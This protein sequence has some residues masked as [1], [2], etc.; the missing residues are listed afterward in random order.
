MEGLQ[1]G[2]GDKDNNSLLATLNVNLLSGGDLEL[3]E[4][5]LELGHVVL[6]VEDGLG[7]G[8]LNLSRLGG[9]RVG[10]SEDLGGVRG[11]LGR[12]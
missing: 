1:L 7:D 2:N 3:L 9:G 4:L 8:L 6:Q 12:I 5:R 10:R 11:H